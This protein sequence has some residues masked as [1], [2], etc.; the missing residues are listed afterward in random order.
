MRL[1]ELI[2]RVDLMRPNNVPEPDKR[3]WMWLVEVPYAEMMGIDPPEWEEL[4]DPEMLLPDRFEQVYIYYLASH[5]DHWQQEID[6]Y[7]IDAMMAQQLDAIIKS[8][9]ARN[10]E[11]KAEANKI[12]GVWI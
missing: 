11:P 7:Q 6:L 8:W 10:G 9:W 1:S 12:K 4:E 2:D 5:I 3:Q